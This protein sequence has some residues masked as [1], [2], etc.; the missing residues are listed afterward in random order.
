[1]TGEE[2]AESRSVVKQRNL[3]GGFFLDLF[4]SALTVRCSFQQIRGS[5]PVTDVEKG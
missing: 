2:K 3:H 1:M 4:A 5:W